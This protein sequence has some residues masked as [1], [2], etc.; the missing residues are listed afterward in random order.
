MDDPSDALSF[1]A[2]PRRHRSAAGLTQEE[3]AERAGLSRRGI[4]D[5][6]R[7]ARRAPYADTVER[8]AA[9]LELSDSEHAALVDAVRRSQRW[10]AVDDISPAQT[11]GRADSSVFVGR[12]AELDVL[13]SACDR[14]GHG[15]GGVVLVAGEPGIGKTTLCQQLTT[16]ALSQRFQVLTG[17]LSEES[18]LSLP[19]LPFVEALRRYA[20]SLPSERV[21]SELGS[22]APRV[23]RVLPELQHRLGVTPSPPT[24][25]EQDRWSLLSALTE[26]MRSAAA[27]QPVVLILED[28]QW[29]DRGTL[30][31][32]LHLSRNM[33]GARLLIIGTYR[34][35]EVDRAHP[36]SSVLMDLRR[37]AGFTR[38]VLPGL[39]YA[40]EGTAERAAA[41]NAMA[42]QLAIAGQEPESRELHLRSLTLT[43]HLKESAGLP[44]DIWWYGNLFPH[45]LVDSWTQ[46]AHRQKERLELATELGPSVFTSGENSVTSVPHPISMFESNLGLF[47]IGDAYLTFGER[48]RAEAIWSQMQRVAAETK[49]PILMVFSHRAR[50][51]LAYLGGNGP[52]R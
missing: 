24:D 45:S 44:Q 9:A 31:L 35:A 48:S 27:V 50:T 46:P 4:A 2:L 25:P 29:A 12:G 7:G 8:L 28:L 52:S 3:L 14:A 47:G 20:Q 40:A 30:D 32:L 38:L 43:R 15:Q 33:A 26:F 11:G 41:D 36:L 6:E 51:I 5:L 1:G 13:R 16:Y 19:Y 23:A 37:G 17:G 22:G 21:A 10:V 39:S 49:V 34:E 18:S 42:H